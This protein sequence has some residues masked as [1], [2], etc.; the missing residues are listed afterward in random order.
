[1]NLCLIYPEIA[2]AQFIN[3]LILRFYFLSVDRVSDYNSS[4][5]RKSET[6]MV[7]G[8]TRS[9]ECEIVRLQNIS[10]NIIKTSKCFTL[11]IFLKH[12]T[13]NIDSALPNN[14]EINT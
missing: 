14:L 3:N 6:A 7:W 1:M 12:L 13:I 4:G 8:K 10:Q 2:S 11:L 5:L 9:A